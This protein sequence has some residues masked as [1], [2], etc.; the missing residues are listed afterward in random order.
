MQTLP[1]MSL[2]RATVSIPM[3]PSVVSQRRPDPHPDHRDQPRST[4]RHQPL[5]FPCNTRCLG[6]TPTC[7]VDRRSAG[8]PGGVAGEWVCV[9]VGQRA[10]PGRWGPE[11]VGSRSH[12]R[13]DRRRSTDRRPR[14]RSRVRDGFR[15][16]RRHPDRRRRQRESIRPQLRRKCVTGLVEPVDGPSRQQRRCLLLHSAS[17]RR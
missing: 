9:G 17:Q 3:W 13:Q 6:S 12:R 10:R 11:G 8:E 15:L 7:P 5:S 1:S 2:R 14:G 16:R 4:R